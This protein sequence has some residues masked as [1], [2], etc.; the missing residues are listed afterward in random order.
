MR[1][2]GAR[3]CPDLIGPIILA[4]GRRV[5]VR[6]SLPQDIDMLRS[7]FRALSEQ[8]R[9]FRFMTKL[10]E[11][12]QSM[13]RGFADIDQLRHV[14]VLAFAGTGGGETMV[15]EARYA[16][17]TEDG[18]GAEF[19]ITVAGD[20]QGLGLARALVARLSGHAAAAGVRR[21]VADTLACNAAMLGL[22]RAA[23]FTV[24]GNGADRRLLRLVKE[25][26]PK[27]QRR[28]LQPCAAPAQAELHCSQGG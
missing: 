5:S 22:A 14:A 8:D 10:G 18:G 17:S 13:A 11:L 12:S 4:D 19:A 21:F 24:N 28:P 2:G 25:L 26:S 1:P 9:Y 6:P 16:L 27:A 3:H 7:F 20:W 15:G 23:G